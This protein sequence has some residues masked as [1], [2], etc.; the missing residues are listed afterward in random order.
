MNQAIDPTI[1][2]SYDIRGIVGRDL[3]EAAVERIG[4][5][6]GT[7]AKE[8]GL[9]KITVGQDCRDSS[10][11]L[12][13]AL[14]RGLTS[15]GMV[16]L[17]LGVVATPMQYF[18]MVQFKADGGLQITGSHN[19]PEYNGLKISLGQ[20]SLHGE[21][22]QRLG[23]IAQEGRFAKGEGRVER[24]DV[25]RP[26]E[27]Y[28][29]NNIRI[30]SRKLKV[31]VDAGN[32]TA[33][34]F[35]VPIYRRLGLEVVPL[36]CE[37]DATFPNHHPDPTVEENLADLRRTVAEQEA[38]L[39]IA[40][41]GDGDRIGVVDE[42]GQILWGDQLMILLARS[43]LQEKPGAT[44]V[45]EVKCSQVLYDDIAKHG[46]KAIMWKTG[47]S[48]IKSKMK[49]VEADL[50]GE[51][52]GHIFFKHRYF[53]FDDATYS[54]A[55]LLEILSHNAAPLS[56]LLADLPKLHSTP[57]IR[58]DCPEALKFKLVQAAVDHFKAAGHR[59]I[60][61]DGARVTFADGWGLVRASNTQPILVLRFE[62]ETAERLREIQSYVE[63][64]LATLRS[65][66]AGSAGQM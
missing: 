41:D 21:E 30:G 13:A 11:K 5:A 45:A 32:G 22:I 49:E 66:L 25:V 23:R 27:D 4:A 36:F 55:R 31:V 14:T 57:E 46:G 6:Y 2:R 48:L 51:M 56:A 35:A 63:G 3:T 59:V 62:A 10:P 61:I 38:D 40:F 26:Y 8:R 18:S 1:F 34:P 17:D 19:P 24:V 54:G 16:V 39:G 37:M 43:I 42:R 50:A 29:A 15:T 44:F 7:M 33:G 52:S 47:H 9:Q 65:S 58:V 64:A 53:G 60:D 20:A 28:I 12:F